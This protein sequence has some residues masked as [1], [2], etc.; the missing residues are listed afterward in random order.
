MTGGKVR[1]CARDRRKLFVP[2]YPAG[3]SRP[4]IDKQREDIMAHENFQECIDACDACAV[5]CDH[6]ATACLGEDDVK[7]MA[8]CIAL[9]MDCAQICRLASALM[10][11]GSEFAGALCRL[12]ADVCQACGDECAKHEADHCREC[13]AACRRCAEVCR[14]MAAAA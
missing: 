13:A 4:A 14:K 1:I 12:C 7:M 5:A 2:M 10:A 3:A 6:C 9:D 11:R 8:R